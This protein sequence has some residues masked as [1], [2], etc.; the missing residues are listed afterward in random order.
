M[1]PIVSFKHILQWRQLIWRKFGPVTEA[2]RLQGF[3]SAF[4][5]DQQPAHRPT[6]SLLI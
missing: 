1:Q 4:D 2:M 6:L 5:L 3:S